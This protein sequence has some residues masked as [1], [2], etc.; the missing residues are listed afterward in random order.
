MSESS[1]NDTAEQ[2]EFRQYCREWLAE[3]KPSDPPVRLPQ[4]AL[5]I[6]TE[7]QLEYLQAWQ[8]SAYEA[9]LVGCDYPKEVG[10]GGRKDCQRV[11]NAEM[12]AAR[13]PFLPNVIGLGMAAPTVFYHARDEL[14]QRLLPRLFSGEDIWCQG[15][16]EPGA[17]S[18][19]ASVQTFAERKGDKWLINGHKVWT[20]LAHFAEWMIILLRTDKS[21]KYDGLSYFVVPIRSAL[22]KGVTVRPLIKITGE[23]GF[24][25]VIFEDLEVDDSYRLDELGKG[26]QVAMTTLLHER[27]AGELQS[28]RSGGMRSKSSHQI[29]TSTL[30]D[31]ARNTRRGEGVAADD[32]LLRDKIMEQMIYEKGFEQNQRRN[33]VQAL[34]D[35]P[36]RLA[37]QNKLLASENAQQIS[38][39]AMEIAGAGSSLYL[40]DENAPA[41]GQWPLSYMNSFGMTI[42][43]GTSEVQR[44]ILGERVLGMPKSK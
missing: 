33:R 4:S 17:G 8:K 42:A 5:E 2:A 27:G 14:K 37:L 19:L 30:I 43:A 11:A 32:P 24:N 1:R 22:G 16:S 6:M 3:N 40:S 25:E 12:I 36:M 31:L 44:N 29:S 7:P 15:F 41:G 13:T 21:H 20:S 34:T 28:P 26:W 23:T 10:G 35:H 38:E 9:G 18:D 39:L